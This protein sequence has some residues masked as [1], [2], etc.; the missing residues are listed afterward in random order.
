MTRLINARGAQVLA[1]ALLALLAVTP[2]RAQTEAVRDFYAGKRLTLIAFAHSSAP[3]WAAARERRLALPTCEDF[4]GQWFPPSC[5]CPHC[6]SARV[7]FTD[8][9]G[10]GTVYSFVTFH[11]VYHPGIRGR[12][13][14]CGRPHR[15]R[16]RPAP[17]VQHCRCC[18]ERCSL[19]NARRG[20]VR[21]LGRGGDPEVPAT[22][23]RTQV[24]SVPAWASS[25]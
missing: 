6:L 24:R 3:Y 1:L 13:A 7:F 9:S 18:A 16:G 5:T 4:S 23:T 11:R 17:S 22:L 8:V 15:A 25:S 12:R 2:A 21:R 10:Q 14:I 20:H 19:R